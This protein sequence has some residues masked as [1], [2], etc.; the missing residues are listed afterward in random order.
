MVKTLGKRLL[1]IFLAIIL[2]VATIPMGIFTASATTV[3]VLDG[4]VSITDTANNMSVSGSTVTVK[5]SGNILSQTTNTITIKNEST[6]TAQISFDYSASNYSSFSESSAS[7]TKSEVL[8]GGAS[9]TMSIKGKRALSGTATLTLSDFSLAVAAT[10]SNV[11]FEFDNNYGSI[12]VDGA[13]INTGDV[14]GIGATNGAT[15]VATATNGATFKGWIDGATGAILSTSANYTIK[16]ASDMTVKAVFIGANSKPHFMLGV[17]NQKSFKCGFLNLGSA[18]YWNIP[19]GSYIFDDLN[20][21]ASAS[22]NTSSKGIVLMNSST[23]PAG[24]YTI[25]SGSVLL[26][27]FDSNNTLYKSD[28]EG[29]EF[30][31]DLDGNGSEED[32]TSE[33]NKHAITY[34]RT[35]TMAS[36]ANIILNG[37]MSLSAKHLWTQGATTGGADESYGIEVASLSG[38]PKTVIE[39]AKEILKKT[40]DEGVVTYKTVTDTSAQLPLEV[41]GATDLLRELKTLDVNTLTPIEAMSVLFDLSNKAKSI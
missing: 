15:L 13:A 29:R 30:K 36:G 9:I 23:L 3:T 1:P 18:D 6:D 14:K 20:A 28:A 17:L 11:T 22:A 34:Y 19:S 12:T 27:P 31:T 16:P 38:I 10:S 21:A 2:V 4:K 26:I 37:E 24:T 33:R 39:R 7:G 41:Q 5:A 35:L 25:P 32:A 8:A 40:L